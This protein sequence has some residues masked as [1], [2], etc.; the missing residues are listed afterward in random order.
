VRSL[1]LT[2]R[3]RLLKPAFNRWHGLNRMLTSVPTPAHEAIIRIEYLETIAACGM[4]EVCRRNFRLGNGKARQ[5]RACPLAQVYSDER[6]AEAY[7]V[8]DAVHMF[9]EQLGIRGEKDRLPVLLFR[10]R[11]IHRTVIGTVQAHSRKRANGFFDP[12]D[13]SFLSGGTL[14][15]ALLTD[16]ANEPLAGRLKE[17]A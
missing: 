5:C 9:Y 15:D 7:A 14:L 1:Y 6:R 2:L 11:L 3:A 13:R 8:I 16:M 12:E 4:N 17:G 10:E